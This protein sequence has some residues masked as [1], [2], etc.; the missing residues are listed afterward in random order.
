[1][2]DPILPPD[3]DPGRAVRMI[4]YVDD[5]DAVA[6][7][8]ASAGSFAALANKTRADSPVTVSATATS[9]LPVTFSTSTPAICTAGGTNGQTITLLAPV[10]RGRKGYHKEVLAAA[11]KLRLREARIDGKRMALADVPLLDRYKETRRRHPLSASPRE[12]TRR[13]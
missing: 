12:E 8:I 4:I 10:V 1:M 13:F 5:P 9:G 7:V 11:R 2:T 3:L 6:I